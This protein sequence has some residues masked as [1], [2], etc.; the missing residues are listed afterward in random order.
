MDNVFQFDQTATI[1][2]TFSLSLPVV[3]TITYSMTPTSPPICCLALTA[4]GT[5]HQHYLLMKNLMVSIVK[6]RRGS[7]CM[8]ML[9]DKEGKEMATLHASLR[10]LLPVEYL[11]VSFFFSPHSNTHTNPLIHNICCKRSHTSDV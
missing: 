9:K 4:G 10:S 5:N 2:P 1:V 11:K 8:E 6:S 3:P 7:S